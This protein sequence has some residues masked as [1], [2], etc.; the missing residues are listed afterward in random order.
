M[1]EQTY[2]WLNTMTLIGFTEKRGHAWHY[3]EEFQGDEPN[4]YPSAIPVPDV[5]RRLFNFEVV[6][7]PLYIPNGDGFVPVPGRKAMVTSDTGDVL[8]VFSGDAGSERG[9]KGHRYQDWLVKNLS[10]ILDDDLGIGSAGLLKNRGQAWVSVEVP[11]SITTPEGVEFRPNLLAATSFD[12]SIATTYKRVVTNVVCDNTL[13][14]GLG[15]EG[16]TFKLRHTRYSDLKIGNAREALAIIH[17]VA[18]DFAKEVAALTA[19]K[20]ETRA[21]DML[22]DAL[23]PVPDFQG[24]KEDKLTT[25]E[26]RS[27]SMAISKRDDLNLLYKKDPRCAPWK[28]T[29]FGVLQAVNTWSHHVQKGVKDNGQ[30][31]QRNMARA[32]SGETVKT[33]M[34]WLDTL[35]EIT[36][37]QVPVLAS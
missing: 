35:S 31:A 3:R 1:S 2:E 5:L 18:D 11:D 20:V 32:L 14:A 15:E 30:R 17:T 10:T 4:H 16:Q 37:Y 6:E 13:A 12:G 19:W 34:E 33:D 7:T 27:L 9:Y 24:R 29:A 21:W 28:G 36:G 23:V 8:G 25:G 26:K 22:L